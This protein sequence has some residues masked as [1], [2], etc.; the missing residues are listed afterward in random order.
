MGVNDDFLQNADKLELIKFIKNYL[1]FD[2][3]IVKKEIKEQW[4][5]NND[6]NTV[7]V[8]GIKFKIN[9]GEK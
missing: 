4:D 7:G 1:I 5:S 8:N 6:I 3:Q 2:E 9:K